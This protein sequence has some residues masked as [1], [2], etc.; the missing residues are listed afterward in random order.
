MFVILF[1]LSE[2]FIFQK[3][4]QI[5]KIDCSHDFGLSK[6]FIVFDVFF[7]TSI[8]KNWFLVDIAIEASKI[9]DIVIFKSM[10]FKLNVS[11]IGIVKS[12]K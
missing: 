5:C 11:L 4:G 6:L 7:Y 9:V 2:F 3:L 10:T 12:G 8:E 1:D